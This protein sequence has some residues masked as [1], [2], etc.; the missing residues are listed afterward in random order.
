MHGGK[1]ELRK[2]LTVNE[3]NSVLRKNLTRFMTFFAII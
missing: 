2:F 1:S 3:I